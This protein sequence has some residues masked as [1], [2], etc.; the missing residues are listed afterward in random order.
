[1]TK[2]EFIKRRARPLVEMMEKLVHPEEVPKVAT[3]VELFLLRMMI[4]VE[5]V[6]DSEDA[7]HDSSLDGLHEP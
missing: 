3:A 1:M 7:G 5:W 4:D 2:S 6:S